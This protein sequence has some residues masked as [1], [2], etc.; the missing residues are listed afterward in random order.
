MTTVKSTVADYYCRRRSTRTSVFSARQSGLSLACRLD[1]DAA[2]PLRSDRITSRLTNGPCAG[3]TSSALLRHSRLE[4]TAR[5]AV[6]NLRH[7]PA[8]RRYRS[9]AD[10]RT[11]PGRRR[12]AA[13]PE[14]C[15]DCH[16]GELLQRPR[17]ERD[18]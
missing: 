16:R 4:R 9:R 1:K 11:K 18:V 8:R 10:G 13:G 15:G 5:Y 14:T 7:H 17:L 3:R 6:A 2:I 12:E